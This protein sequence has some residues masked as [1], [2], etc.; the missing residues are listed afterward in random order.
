M[1]FLTLAFFPRELAIR[2]LPGPFACMW[3]GAYGGNCFPLPWHVHDFV[4][5]IKVQDVAEGTWSVLVLF[6]LAV[7]QFEE[8]NWAFDGCS[9]WYQ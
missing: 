4:R 5:N 3:A 7:W 1:P 9:C 6:L 2:D 8:L